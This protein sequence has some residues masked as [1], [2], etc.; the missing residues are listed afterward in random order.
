MGGGDPRRFG[1]ARAAARA[2]DDAVRGG[3][4]RTMRCALI[5]VQ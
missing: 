2:G 5:R 4:T 1:V 3:L